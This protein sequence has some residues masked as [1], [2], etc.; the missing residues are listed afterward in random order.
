[1]KP[2]VMSRMADLTSLR[3]LNMEE[4]EKNKMKIFGDI[5]EAL[6]GAVLID[7]GCD[8]SRTREVFMNLF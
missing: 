8:I 7:T 4:S 2:D 5:L 6:F 3:R 1:M